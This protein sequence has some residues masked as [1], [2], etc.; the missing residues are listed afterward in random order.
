MMI[1]VRGSQ[2]GARISATPIEGRGSVSK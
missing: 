1:I 2:G